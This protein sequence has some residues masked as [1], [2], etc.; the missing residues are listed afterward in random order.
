MSVSNTQSGSK[1]ALIEAL[2]GLAATAVVFY[3]TARH[4]DKAYGT[5]LLR[6][7][8]QFGHA[9]VDLFFVLSGFIILFV[10]FRDIG[11]PGRLSYYANRRFTRVMPTYWVAPNNYDSHDR[12]G[13]RSISRHQCQ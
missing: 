9:G 11:Q 7:I 13:Q 4:T 10:H 8:F 3:H 12:R 6:Q 1:F 5:P 2:R